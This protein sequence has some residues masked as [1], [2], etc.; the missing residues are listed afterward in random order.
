MDRRPAADDTDTA[1]R[2]TVEMMCE[3]I[4]NAAADPLVRSC[5]D[6]AWRRFGVGSPDPSMK[7]WGVFWWVKHCLK[8]RQDE[9]T[10][11]RVGERDQQDLLTSPEVLFRLKDPAE[12]CDGF[13]MAEA[14]MLTVLGVPLVIATVAADARDRGR[15][16]HV[17]PMA[18]INGSPLPLDASHGSGPGWMVPP[19]HIYR[20]QAWDLDARPVDIQPMRYRGLHGLAAAPPGGRYAYGASGRRRALPVPVMLRRRGMGDCVTDPESGLV[21]CSGSDVYTSPGYTATFP[22]VVPSSGSSAPSSSGFNLTSFLNTLVSNAG[23]VAKVAE[24]PITTI[25]YPGGPTISTPGGIPA[26]SSLLGGASLTSLLPLLGVGLVAL[27]AIS[28]MGKK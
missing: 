16:S 19:E 26:A 14:A 12:D 3:Y 9:A 27:L 4:R 2:Q 20:F 22:S 13:T 1:T 17:F 11:F 8:F 23:A 18:L 24:T 28:A 6:Y 21:D 5:A 10:M 15:W 7:A 25:S